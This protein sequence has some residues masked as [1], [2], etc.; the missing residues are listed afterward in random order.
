MKIWKKLIAVGS[1]FFSSLLTACVASENGQTNNADFGS[2]NT[3]VDDKEAVER[4]VRVIITL[5]NSREAD[6]ARIALLR[7]GAI[8][9]DPIEGQPMIVVEALRA[10]LE[11]G[12]QDI[13]VKSI[14]HD[15]LS[16]S[17]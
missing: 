1:L 7:A 3:L 17:N 16:P 13:E 15:S 6:A 11:A 10:Q 12:L 4:P 14:Q 8:L 2:G 5:N 9:V